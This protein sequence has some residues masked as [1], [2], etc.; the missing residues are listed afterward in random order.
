M[1]KFCKKCQ[2][3]KN[4]D[5]FT[6]QAGC[7]DGRRTTC[8]TCHC[9]VQRERRKRNREVVFDHY[10]S[11]KMCGNSDRDILTIDHI[12]DDGNIK[13]KTGEHSKG[14]KFYAWIIRNNFPVD[15]QSLCWN[16][17]HKKKF[18]QQKNQTVG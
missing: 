17:Q 11:C 9:L 13:R 6:K 1:K 3:F 15:L 12:N 5:E 10:G 18:L 16:C 2:Q 8:K 4:I 14:P 7:K